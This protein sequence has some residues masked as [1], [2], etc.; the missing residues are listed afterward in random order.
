MQICYSHQFQNSDRTLLIKGN[1]NILRIYSPQ[2]I[3]ILKDSFDIIYCG[4]DL[5]LRV[6]CW[7]SRMDKISIINVNKISH[8]METVSRQ[9]IIKPSKV[10]RFAFIPI[11]CICSSYDNFHVYQQATRVSVCFN[12]PPLNIKMDQFDL[13]GKA[14]H[15]CFLQQQF[16]LIIML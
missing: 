7:F 10:L 14:V 9:N 1:P 13:Q 16:Y 6:K 15:T 4:L 3:R 2:H 8:N 11:R 5:G 12:F